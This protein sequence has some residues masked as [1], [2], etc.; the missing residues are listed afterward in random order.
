MGLK[1]CGQCSEMVDEAKAFCPGCGNAFVEEQKR[2]A[3]EFD[4]LDNTVQFGQTM[5]NQMLSDMGLNISKQPEPAK[6]PESVVRRAE[7]PSQTR[8][9]VI[10]PA[11]AAPA[12][13]AVKAPGQPKPASYT[14]WWIL[15]GV[16]L[17]LLFLLLLA[18]AAALFIY[19]TRFRVV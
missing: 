1:Q 13:P 19:W 5:Y 2:E 6:A 18:A 12:K 10:V 8:I 4:R 9:E 7:K 16:A 14:K 11:A 17:L 15:G 3:S